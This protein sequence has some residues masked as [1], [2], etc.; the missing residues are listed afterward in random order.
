MGGIRYSLTKLVAPHCGTEPNRHEPHRRHDPN[1]DVESC[2]FEIDSFPNSRF[3]GLTCIP[4]ESS[5]V[6]Q[7]WVLP[8]VR[9][10]SSTERQQADYYGSGILIDVVGLTPSPCCSE[11]LPW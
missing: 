10:F 6:D 5:W 8:V 4:L 2:A 7:W 1:N 11:W 9:S 3:L